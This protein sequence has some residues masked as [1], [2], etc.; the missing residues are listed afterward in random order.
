[1]RSKFG[2]SPKFKGE[3]F[4]I[5]PLGDTPERMDVRFKDESITLRLQFVWET[6]NDQWVLSQQIPDW[7]I[8]AHKLWFRGQHWRQVGILTGEE[9]EDPNCFVDMIAEHI[10]F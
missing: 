1:M 6:Y 7:E 10:E 4:E 2:D 9:T 3:G 8:P 5:V